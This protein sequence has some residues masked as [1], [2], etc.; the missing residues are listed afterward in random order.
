M[1]DYFKRIRCHDGFCRFDNPNKTAR[2]RAK[3]EV[4]KELEKAER[5]VLPSGE[6]ETLAQ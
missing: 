5:Q 3:R 4:K 1:R 6:G 2:T